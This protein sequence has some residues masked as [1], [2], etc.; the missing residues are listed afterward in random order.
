M[1]VRDKEVTKY[2]ILTPAYLTALH[3][4]HHTPLVLICWLH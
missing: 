2:Y 3:M 4:N 1:H